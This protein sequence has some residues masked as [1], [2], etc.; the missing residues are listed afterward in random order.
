MNYAEDYNSGVGGGTKTKVVSWSPS[1]GSILVCVGVCGLAFLLFWILLTQGT[2]T[3]HIHS[4]MTNMESINANRNGGRVVTV[5]S[6]MNPNGQDIHSRI[7]MCSKEIYYTRYGD[8]NDTLVKLDMPIEDILTPGMINNYFYPISVTLDIEFN[9]D[10]T[11]ISSTNSGSL[12]KL[13]PSVKYMTFSYN[14]TTNYP[15]F[16]TIKLIEVEFNPFEQA[17]R[18][19]RNILMCSNSHVLDTKRCDRHG[20]DKIVTLHNKNWRPIVSGSGQKKPLD[21]PTEKPRQTVATTTTNEDKYNSANTE[22][23]MYDM[24]ESVENS[25]SYVD[26][27]KGEITGLRLYNVLFYKK[28]L[29]RQ[30]MT[31]NGGGGNP[32]YSNNNNER[33]EERVLT[34]ELRQC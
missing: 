17:L 12:F 21:K 7:R 23:E 4:V 14:I 8:W 15:F 27:Q 32:R 9:V 5:S 13:N 16:S 28:N 2:Q 25:F 24:I 33:E 11:E 20:D 29:N 30:S 34:L 18:P 31:H 6:M 19:P 22:E 1:I 26:A 10:T 3:G